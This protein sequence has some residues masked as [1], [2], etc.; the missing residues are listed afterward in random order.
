MPGQVFNFAVIHT[1]AVESM[2]GLWR[3]RFQEGA[4]KV[5]KT[6]KFARGSCRVV[7][8][9]WSIPY[10]PLAVTEQR[11]SCMESS[12][13]AIGVFLSLCLNFCN[14]LA[15]DRRNNERMLF[16]WESVVAPFTYCISNLWST[17]G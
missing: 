15:E 6:M 16:C 7:Q 11:L 1:S 2:G 17:W 3:F 4:R 9:S 8:E 12:P 5:K 13:V 14:S 10:F